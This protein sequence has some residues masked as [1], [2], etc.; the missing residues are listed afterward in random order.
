MASALGRIGRLRMYVA[1]LAINQRSLPEALPARIR[2]LLRRRSLPEGVPTNRVRQ[3]ATVREVLFVAAHR[4][5]VPEA[6]QF[7]LMLMRSAR[8]DKKVSQ[9]VHSDDYAVVGT[10]GSAL[11]TLR[12]AR[13]LGVRAIL[14]C[15]IAHHEFAER[16]LT[17]EATLQPAF[18]KTLQYHKFGSRFRDR[19]QQEI[20][21]ADYILTL[22]TF[23]RRTFANAG[24]NEAKI[25]TIP[26]GVDLELF[27][28]QPRLD[29]SP[30][31]VIFVGQLTQRK[32]LSYVLDGFNLAAIPNAEL[33][34]VGR[35]VQ[36]SDPW[37]RQHN[38]RHI[39]HV[40]RW[41]LPRIY[42]DADIFVLPSLIEGFGLTALEAMASGLPVIV[43]ENTFAHDI[44]RDGVDGYVVP[45][46]DARAIADRLR[47]LYES[48]YERRQLGIAARR[49]AEE[50]SWEAYHSALVT[51]FEG[52]Q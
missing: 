38:V 33:L 3:V 50:F 24:V 13:L 2:N 36:S 48:P 29:G 44:V 1:P 28:P 32:G 19:L 39:S 9:V 17:E 15:P 31:R 8:F 42:Q 34:L 26:L 25:I 43:S 37:T 30:L 35:E 47:F 27:R 49:R 16:L 20:A 5:P 52:L 46:R 40:A 12:A 4:D 22:S 18:A 23:Q 11:H 41:E 10:S 6:V 45:I 51:A 21:Q 7:R 14:N